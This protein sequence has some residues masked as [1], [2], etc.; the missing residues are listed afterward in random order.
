V[1]RFLRQLIQA[2]TLDPKLYDECA[3]DARL[4]WPALLIVVASGV[5]GTLGQYP[6]RNVAADALL[7]N[8]WRAPLVWVVSWPVLAGAAYALGRWGLGGEGTFGGLFRGLGW[9]FAPGMLQVVIWLRALSFVAF[10]VP[11]VW[12]VAAGMAATARTLR[13]SSTRAMIATLAAWAVWL[14]VQLLVLLALGMLPS[15]TT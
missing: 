3:R 6:G 5:A 2:A 9:A 13:I 1:R 10:A 7:E 15:F 8:L 12:I 4:V 14:V 11:M